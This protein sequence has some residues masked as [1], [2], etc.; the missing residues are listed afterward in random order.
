MSTVIEH[1]V[2][3][4]LSSPSPVLSERT[5]SEL[6]PFARGDVASSLRLSVLAGCAGRPEK[7]L[8][9]GGVDADRHEPFDM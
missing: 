2:P 9:A 4:R 5:V 1:T 8:P 6:N 7:R 3:P